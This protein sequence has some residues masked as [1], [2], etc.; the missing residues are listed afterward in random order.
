[1]YVMSIVCMQSNFL[2]LTKTGFSAW[3]AKD[4]SDSA[5]LRCLITV[6]YFT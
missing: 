1:M 3:S 6:Y 2:Y 5:T 4:V